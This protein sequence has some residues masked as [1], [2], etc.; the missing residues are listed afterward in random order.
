MK[1]MKEEFY[2]QKLELGITFV[3]IPKNMTFENYLNVPEPMVEWKLLANLNINLEFICSCDYC[4]CSH[5][6]IREY[7]AI[8]LDDFY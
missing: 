5:P 8:Y 3:S 4:R 6:L 7:F 1:I 2:S